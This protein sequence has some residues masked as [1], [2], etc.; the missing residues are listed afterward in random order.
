MEHMPRRAVPL[1]FMESVRPPL[2]GRSRSDISGEPGR[3]WRS[4]HNR[5]Y[6]SN[7]SR[8]SG[9]RQISGR[10]RLYNFNVRARHPRCWTRWRGTSCPRFL[11]PAATD[12][13][14]AGPGDRAVSGES[15]GPIAGA[16]ASGGI[17]APD[18]EHLLGTRPSS[19]LGQ[20]QSSI[21]NTSKF[22][23]G[24]RREPAATAPKRA[25]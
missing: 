22:A 24:S 21:V 11:G 15:G 19:N 12:E 16:A 9:R 25:G 20:D 10:G 8:I 5:R 2:D 4:G 6:R 23:G 14:P 3:R 7:F 17:Y 1:R 18:A 13:A